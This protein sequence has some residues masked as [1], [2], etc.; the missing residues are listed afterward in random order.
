[1]SK[2][3]N[4]KSLATISQNLRKKGKEIE[5]ETVSSQRPGAIRSQFKRV[6]L[7]LSGF[8]K[9]GTKLLKR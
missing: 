4:L 9:L 5:H 8:K 7:I 6:I 2:I 3:H 1:M